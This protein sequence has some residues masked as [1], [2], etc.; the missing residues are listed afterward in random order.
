MAANRKLLMFPGDGIGPEVMRQVRR[1][2]DW[3]AKGRHASFNVA[4]ALVVLA[5]PASAAAPTS[6]ADIA[7]TA[8]A[9]QPRIR[10]GQQA[11]LTVTAT[12]LGPLPATDVVVTNP[13]PTSLTLVDASLSAG[14]HDVERAEVALKRDA[15]AMQDHDAIGVVG[16]KRLR[17]AD[18]PRGAD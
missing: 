2:V 9:S 18:R 4:E 10:L 11:T 14:H 17:E 8:L 15:P 1:V 5:T 6:G 12:N 7:V 3:L 16:L 13:L